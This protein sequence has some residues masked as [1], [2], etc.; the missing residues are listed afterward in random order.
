LSIIGRT[1]LGYLHLD[2][3]F[4]LG[5]EVLKKFDQVKGK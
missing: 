3:M 2:T 1:V 4:N 5:K